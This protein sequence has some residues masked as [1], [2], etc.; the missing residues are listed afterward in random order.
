MTPASF[1]PFHG[2]TPPPFPY[3]MGLYSSGLPQYNYAELLAIGRPGSLGRLSAGMLT[4]DLFGSPS[5]VSNTPALGKQSAKDNDIAAAGRATALEASGVERIAL[6]VLV[7]V[8][9]LASISAALL[10][11]WVLGRR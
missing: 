2:P 6:P 1:G 5:A 11:S 3:A 7:A 4:A 9:M 10:R 8:L